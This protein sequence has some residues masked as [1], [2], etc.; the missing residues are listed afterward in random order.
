MR[1]LLTGSSGF[2]GTNVIERAPTSA[3][4]VMPFDKVESRDVLNVDKLRD[5]CRECEAIV[6][7]AGWVG[8]HH[9]FSHINDVVVTN[10]TGT[11]NVLE[12]ATAF[13]VPVVVV[14]LKNDWLNPYMITKQTGA[15]F[16]QIYHRYRGT[17]TVLLRAMNVYGPH[18]GTDKQ[19]LVPD[20]I[21]NAL[22]GLPL[23]VYGDGKQ[24]IDMTHI[25]DL[26]DVIFR[27]LDRCVW[28]AEIEVGTGIPTTVLEVAQALEQILQKPIELKMM[29]MRIGEPVHSTSLADCAA[30]KRLLDYYPTTPWREGLR[31]IVDWYAANIE[32]VCARPN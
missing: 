16:V 32:Y 4:V 18:Q 12:V 21:V 3:H 14:S 23:S 20:F 6:H 28:G 9:S 27:S 10:I 30:M 8:T 13:E 2:V 17:K 1:L 7:C 29:P 31:Q 26:V 24:I 19:K 25:N 22:R 5:A 11:L 15:K